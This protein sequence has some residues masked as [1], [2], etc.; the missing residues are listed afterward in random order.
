MVVMRLFLSVITITAITAG[1]MLLVPAYAQSQ[2][3]TMTD[4][5]IAR[6]KANCGVALSTLGRIHANDAPVYINRNQT[7]FSISDKMMA[8]LNSR[9]TLNRFDATELVQISSDFNA[10]LEEFRLAYKAYDNTMADL[11]RMDCTRAPVSFYDMV[12][13]ARIKREAVHEIVVE[14]QKLIDQYRDAVE[15]FKTDNSDKLKDSDNE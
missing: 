5:H 6:I 1:A 3:Q 7:Y 11:V 14:M 12:A 15:K 4:D 9:L 8:R 13:D 2:S 10:K